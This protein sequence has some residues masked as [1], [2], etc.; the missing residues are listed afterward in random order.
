M[1]RYVIAS[2][3]LV[4]LVVVISSC[5]RGAKPPKVDYSSD[6]RNIIS[7]EK[8]DT[9]LS[10]CPAGTILIPNGPMIY[11]PNEE[12]GVAASGKEERINVK[13]FCID[14]FEYPNE[15]GER[16]ARS[17]AWLE[18]QKLCSN[19]GKRL[20]TEYEWEKACRGPAGTRYAYGDGFAAKLC[21]SASD[22]YG[23]GQYTN[24]VSGFGVQDM[25]GGVFEW[26]NSTAGGSAGEDLKILRGGLS[27]DNPAASARC[28]YR[29]R[30]SS[31][32]SGRDVG[33]R[34][35]STPSKEE[36]SK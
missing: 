30:Y 27:N 23:L 18:A 2:I 36:L 19:R 20:C 29:V 25:S 6:K 22:E 32:S 15:F 5:A 35:C 17:I 9:S 13:G 33:V 7:S 24:C 16:P 21:P 8:G 31:V 14:K 3:L 1:L 34:C 11:G 28:T 4:A 26:T 10:I 12:K